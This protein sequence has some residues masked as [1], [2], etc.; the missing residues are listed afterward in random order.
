M[1]SLFRRS[2]IARLLALGAVAIV[3]AGAEKGCVFGVN[4][5]D[6]PIEEVDDG[7]GDG[8]TFT[9]TLVLRNSAGTEK[10][11]FSTEELITFELRV[12]NLTD[13]AQ[14]VDLSSTL[15]TDFLVY[16]DGEETAL[17]TSSEGIAA[18]T[19]ITPLDFEPN[20]TKVMSY[21]WNQV[22]SDGSVLGTGDYDA[23][24]LVAAVGVS[25]NAGA[26]HELRSVLKGFRVE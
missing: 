5:D 12:R 14:T 16:D 17:W 10:Y 8:D 13:E 20:E 4:N 19:V 1:F 2:M 26:P 18:P 11:T 6:D 23:R 22:L 7:S 21:T 9:T 25:A 15:A 3:T 24:G